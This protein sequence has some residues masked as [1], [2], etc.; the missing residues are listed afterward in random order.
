MTVPGSA[1]PTADDSFLAR[2]AGADVVLA[3]QV[4]VGFFGPASVSWRV[5]A[6]PSSKLGGV[7]AMLL[8]LLNPDLMRLFAATV[9][10]AAGSGT[11]AARTSAYQDTIIFGNR[12]SAEAAAEATNLRR[13]KNS[14][15]DPFTGELLRADNEEWL[16]WGHNTLVYALLR[17][18]EAFGPELT[19]EE[20]DRFIVEQHIAACL[21][22]IEDDELLPSSRAE[23]ESY[24]NVNARWMALTVS[25]ADAVREFGTPPLGESPVR[26]WIAE[27]AYDAALALLPD[28]ALKLYGVETGSIRL[29]A[30]AKA[31]RRIVESA[32]KYTSTDEIIKDVSG[33]F[34]AQPSRRDE[35]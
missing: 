5:F 12:V 16:A 22:E 8:H 25:A 21:I 18:T 24:I 13:S 29:R 23:L 30:A 1:A 28:W 26:V 7:S 19:A 17:A 6:D 10:S 35:R 14:W 34:E 33:R 4:D 2:G 32:R 15:R 31:T 9:D 27:N 20:Q 11:W 3:H